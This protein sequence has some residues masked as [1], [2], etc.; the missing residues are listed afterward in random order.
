MYAD[1]SL[2]LNYFRNSDLFTRAWHGLQ[3][4]LTQLK[5]HME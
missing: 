1:L 4:S 2:Q 5:L 3:T